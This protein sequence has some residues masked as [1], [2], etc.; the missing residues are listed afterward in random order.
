[1][2]SSHENKL[3][4][5]L[6]NKLENQSQK[7]DEISPLKALELLTNSFLKTLIIDVCKEPSLSIPGS[8]YLKWASSHHSNH[9]NH[10]TNHTNHTNHNSGGGNRQ[11]LNQSNL[12]A[13]D[14]GINKR[15]AMGNTDMAMGSHSSSDENSTE[16]DTATEYSDVDTISDSLSD[17][18]SINSPLFDAG[19]GFAKV[20]NDAWNQELFCQRRVP[21]HVLVYDE[22]G[23]GHAASVVEWLTRRNQNTNN[24]YLSVQRI[25][26]GINAFF[27]EF[28]LLDRTQITTNHTSI[29]KNQPEETQH[30]LDMLLKKD[31]QSSPH[32]QKLLGSLFGLPGPNPLD[33]L[34]LWQ[35]NLIDS[36][37]FGKKNGDVPVPIIPDFLY[38]SS[39]YGCTRENLIRNGIKH[40]LRLGWGFHTMVEN[41]GI[42]SSS[43][44]SFSLLFHS[45]NI[46]FHEFRISDSPS[47]PI[48][49]V[50]E[51][52]GNLINEIHQRGER[53]LVHCYAGVS[54]SSS[55]ILAY[56]MKFRQM[57][58]YDS[59]NLTYKVLLYISKIDF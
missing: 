10:H 43:I 34:K 32:H 40:V 7:N 59:W 9:S 20:E 53:V 56:L 30:Y 13:T 17:S 37:W 36:V 48:R 5:E 26:G 45:D 3:E 52:T 35:K 49:Q 58:L 4:N 14:T 44:L 47:Q 42:F 12:V 57:S 22:N 19:N 2:L 21:I 11:H 31:H 27:K 46:T 25:E 28:P 38:L 8:K 16:S 55:V 1:M 41:E 54:R 39:C 6:E 29:I 15:N 33:A 50:L 23:I 24:S 51:E 18:S